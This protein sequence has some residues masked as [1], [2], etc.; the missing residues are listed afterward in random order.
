MDL[1]ADEMDIRLFFFSRRS[2]AAEA[3]KLAM[4]NQISFVAWDLAVA[5]G[6]QE[7]GPGRQILRPKGLADQQLAFVVETDQPL[8]N[9]LSMLAAS[10]KPF[11]NRGAQDCLSGSRL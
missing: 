9:S 8:S 10:S 1:M 7:P 3:V 11:R 6:Y 5:V 2:I 4:I